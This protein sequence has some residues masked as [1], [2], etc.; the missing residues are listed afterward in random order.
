MAL[1]LSKLK[2]IERAFKEYKN[3]AFKEL[4]P[5]GWFTKNDYARMKNVSQATAERHINRLIYL[6]KIKICSYSHRRSD[7]TYIKIPHYFLLQP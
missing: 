4:P 2:T 1:D 5:A 7:G 3:G 6:K